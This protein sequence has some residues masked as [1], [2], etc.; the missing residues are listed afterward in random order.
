MQGR[1]HADRKRY[2]A[3]TKRVGDLVHFTGANVIGARG[4]TH[5][6]KQ[7]DATRAGRCRTRSL[8][9]QLNYPQR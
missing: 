9:P 8:C 6:T 3:G 4:N 1:E 7:L 5:N 2:H